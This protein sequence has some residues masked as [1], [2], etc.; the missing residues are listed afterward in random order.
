[1]SD[2]PTFVQPLLPPVLLHAMNDSWTFLLETR[3][4]QQFIFGSIAV[5]GEGEWIHLE[6][7]DPETTDFI[8]GPLKADAYRITERGVSV[9]VS[10]IA[11]VA[12]GY[13]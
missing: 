7:A 2:I 1:M 3:S 6:P 10:E 4:G 8:D 12:E 9:R 5:V 13:S 11:W